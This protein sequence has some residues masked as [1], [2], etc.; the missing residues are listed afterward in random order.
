MQNGATS[1]DLAH[2]ILG[3]Q[4]FNADHPDN[5]SFVTTLYAT[6]LG[7]SPDP[8][9]LASWLQRLQSGT[10]RDQAIVTFLYSSE[11]YLRYI[12][13]AYRTI[14]HRPADPSG[15]QATLAWALANRVD[16]PAIAQALL[17]SDE[18]FSGA[19]AAAQN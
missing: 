2:T 3:S 9:G 16:P 13:G 1:L 5:Q 19:R 15:Q 11:A 4:E 17:A 18:Y 8:A 6:V 14:L 7:R 12:D 10:T